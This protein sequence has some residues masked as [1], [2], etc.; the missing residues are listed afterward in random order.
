M[1]EFRCHTRLFPPR[2]PSLTGVGRGGEERRGGDT[3]KEHHSKR[4]QAGRGREGDR[5]AKKATRSKKESK[6]KGASEVL[7]G[8]A[9]FPLFWRV[10][11]ALLYVVACL[12]SWLITGLGLI[13]IRPPL[14]PSSLLPAPVSHS[15]PQKDK[16]QTEN[17]RPSI[18]RSTAS[19]QA[20]QAHPQQASSIN[21]GRAHEKSSLQRH[22]F[23]LSSLL[24]PRLSSTPP[25]HSFFPSCL[26]P[27][28]N[29]TV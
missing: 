20:S 16:G 17:T 5:E 13:K 10:R 11:F 21:P 28:S 9:S 15:K 14:S 3:P 2:L 1:N 29:S 24:S 26:F 27:Q 4:I 12:A 25:I 6:S 7:G 19:K 22:N 8:L 23:Y 18:D